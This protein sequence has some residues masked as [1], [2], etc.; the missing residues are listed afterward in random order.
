LGAE[1]QGGKV[2]T[3]RNTEGRR[4]GAYSNH[5]GSIDQAILWNR[6]LTT[7]DFDE[8][9]NFGLGVTYADT[10]TPG[11]SLVV[12]TLGSLNPAPAAY[13]E[14][15]WRLVPGCDK[16]FARCKSLG[17]SARFRGFPHFPKSNPALIPIKQE[18]PAG[19]KK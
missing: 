18:S 8:L 12:R 6:A 16:S 1:G 17:N 7:D 11:D 14:E 15:G 2:E 9:Y 19:G 10:A 5:Y 3:G 4:A 13:P